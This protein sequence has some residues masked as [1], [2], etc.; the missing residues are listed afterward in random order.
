[1]SRAAAV[2]CGFIRYGKLMTDEQNLLTRNMCNGLVDV[3]KDAELTYDF[4][5]EAN[6][7]W[8]TAQHIVI[9]SAE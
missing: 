2:S 9:Q 5:A 8:T 1:M 4:T 7:P 6:P 3:A